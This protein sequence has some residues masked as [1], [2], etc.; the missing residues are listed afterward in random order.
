[1]RDQLSRSSAL[2]KWTKPRLLT[3]SQA[4]IDLVLEGPRNQIRAVEIKRSSAPRVS[5][6][7][8]EGCK[9]VGATEKFV[10]YPGT[11][12]FPI[13]KDIEAIGVAEFLHMIR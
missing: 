6:G 8:H 12:R 2:V 4:H 1:M 11:E 9:D 5:R 10:I 3:K 7:F 13:A